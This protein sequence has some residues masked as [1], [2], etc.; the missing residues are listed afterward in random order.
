MRMIRREADQREQ[1]R[2]PLPPLSPVADAVHQQRLVEDG[3]DA[4]CAG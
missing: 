2:H 1:R 3:A 4:S